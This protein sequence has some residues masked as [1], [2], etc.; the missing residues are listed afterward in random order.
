MKTAALLIVAMVVAIG[1]LL[2]TLLHLGWGFLVLCS[3][4]DADRA[5]NLK[6]VGEQVRNS[7]II[8]S[9][10]IDSMAELLLSIGCAVIGRRESTGAAP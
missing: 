6:R 4:P 10:M 9:I 3:R 5:N 8:C 2:A 7:L 1:S